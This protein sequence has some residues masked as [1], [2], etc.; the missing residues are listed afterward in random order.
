[1]KNALHQFKSFVSYWLD[2]VNAHS[3]HSPFLF[4][5]HTDVIQ[6]RD[7]QQ[8]S[9][10][11]EAIRRGLLLDEREIEVLDFGSGASTGKGS[12]RK[13]S[14]IARTSLSPAKYSQLYA[15]LIQRY[16]CMHILE[17]GTSLGINTLYLASDAQSTVHTFEGSPSIAAVAKTNFDRTPNINLVIGEIERT[18]PQILSAI[19]S[20]DFVFIDANHRFIPTL[21]YFDM[22]IRKIH[23]E[24]IVVLDDI[25]YSPE[26]EKAW[27]EIK[28][29]PRVSV[30]VD[31]FRCGIV[32]FNGALGRQHVVLEF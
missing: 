19:E 15:R 16:H 13:I 23:S 21:K 6:N 1:L 18:L 27:K 31:I 32:F 8:Y 10:N 29:H 14:E 22:L 9:E 24:S 30:T 12:R 5:L 26:M 2:E 20:L 11:I 28:E 4:D 25:H 3:L 7:R 17:L